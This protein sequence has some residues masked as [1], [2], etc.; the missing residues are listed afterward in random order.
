MCADDIR[1]KGDS[2]SSTVPDGWY[3]CSGAARKVGRSAD[4][5]RRWHREGWCR[6]S[7]WKMNGDLKVWLYSEEDIAEMRKLIKTA[8][9]GRKRKVV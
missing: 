3:T 5:L 4:T 1:G 7:G 6:P 2:I 9:P 8:R